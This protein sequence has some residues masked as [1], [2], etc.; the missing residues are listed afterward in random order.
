MNKKKAVQLTNNTVMQKF[1]DS[2]TWIF[3]SFWPCALYA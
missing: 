3:F 2:I 1:K